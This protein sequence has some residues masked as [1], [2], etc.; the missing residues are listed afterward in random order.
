MVFQSPISVPYH[1]EETEVGPVKEASVSLTYIRFRKCAQLRGV[2]KHT[3]T[4]VTPL[5]H[6]FIPFKY[7]QEP[8]ENRPGVFTNW[9]HINGGDVVRTRRVLRGTSECFALAFGR[10]KNVPFILYEPFCKDIPA[11]FALAYADRIPRD[12]RIMLAVIDTEIVFVL[13]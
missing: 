5:C 11:A 3:P 13:Q 4:S 6:G 8:V 9:T 1:C 10:C 12:D 7:S 2:T